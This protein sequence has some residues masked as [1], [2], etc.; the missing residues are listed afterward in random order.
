MRVW[1]CVDHYGDFL[2]ITEINEIGQ[3]RQWCEDAE[4]AWNIRKTTLQAMGWAGVRQFLQERGKRFK[5][6]RE[7]G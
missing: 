2:L 1:R 3:Y 4:L 7:N 5:E 6:V